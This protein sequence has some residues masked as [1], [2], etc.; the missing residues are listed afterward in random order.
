MKY[1]YQD[2][3]VKELLKQKGDDINKSTL[4]TATIGVYHYEFGHYTANSEYNVQNAIPMHIAKG[5]VFEVYDKNGSEYSIDFTVYELDYPA[6]HENKIL[7]ILE[8]I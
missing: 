4:K 2:A 8:I 7:C 5:S 3:I 1:E 6:G